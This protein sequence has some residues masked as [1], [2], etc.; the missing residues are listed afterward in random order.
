LGKQ[1]NVLGIGPQKS[2]LGRSVIAAAKDGN[3]AVDRFEAV[4]DRSA[5]LLGAERVIAI[6]T[7]P[8]RLALA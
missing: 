3:L 2:G 8:E 5:F 6:D 4:A 7:V 1:R